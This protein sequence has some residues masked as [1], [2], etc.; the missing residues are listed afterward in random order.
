MVAVAVACVVLLGGQGTLARWTGTSNVTAGSFSTG[1]MTL[2]PITSYG[3]GGCTGW[4]FSATG[5]TSTGAAT[6]ST[7]LQP[8]DVLVDNCYYTLVA[9]GDNLKGHYAVSWATASVPSYA[10]VS[11]PVTTVDGASRTT[12]TGADNNTV[13]HV[14]VQI[15]IDS[16]YDTQPASPAT[17]TVP[18]L[19]VNAVQDTP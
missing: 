9:K 17:F 11:T 8:G 6:P 16:G 5:G 1:A 2:T 10:T 7:P 14:Q 4:S 15:A 19:T 12:F 18:A 13:V 3:T